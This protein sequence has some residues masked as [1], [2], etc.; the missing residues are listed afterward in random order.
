L[1]ERGTIQMNPHEHRTRFMVDRRSWL[2]GSGGGFGM[3]ALAQM[4]GQ[5]ATALALG[6]DSLSEDQAR[7]KTHFAP[8]AKRIINIFLEGGLSHM[9]CFDP[10]PELVQRHN[11]A[12]P[13]A[14][15]LRGGA[16]APAVSSHRNIAYG[17]PFHFEKHGE[18]GLEI[19]ELFPNLA[20][21]ADKLCVIRSMHGDDPGHQQAMMLMNCGDARLVRPATGSW[22]TYGLGSENENLPGYIV[23]YHES[24][25]L[26]GSENWQAAFL[27]GI[28]QG[29]SVDTQ[30]EQVDKL[31]SNIQSHVTRPNVQRRQMELLQS[32]NRLHQNHER[33]HDERLE[34]RIRSSELAFRMQTEATQA[35]DL[36]KETEETRELYGETGSGRQCMLARR[37]AES[38]VRFVQLYC[39]QWDHHQELKSS[40][41]ESAK[42]VDQAIAA[43]LTDLDRRGMLEDTL[44]LCSSE[45]GRT[46]T[47]DMNA[48]AA[49]K[50]P[51]RDHNHR[52][53]SIW[54]AGG[55]VRGGMAHGATDE[56]G[57]AATSDPVH[58]HDLHATI[59]HLM[60][61]DHTRLT[62]RYA[63][64][65]FRL[66][67]VHGNVVKAILS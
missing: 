29:T 61:I 50:A 4:L 38:G 67:D 51:G 42:G 43:L 37:L 22:L 25:P 2:K 5:P 40:I 54:M 16:D 20:T 55:G 23:L 53:F 34:A 24:Q 17:S 14:D 10:K 62:Y 48:G 63:G 60:G 36:S 35:F 8:R 49:G 57:W 46:P 39:G 31:L 6:E 21:H 18:S 56:F 65:D 19:S 13:H 3:L 44:V 41:A 59:L 52:G 45:F 1:I 30:F 66:T 9:D 15:E 32:L 11:T 33:A 47:A 26:K 58:V 28:Y 27:P 64:R 12:I 7:N